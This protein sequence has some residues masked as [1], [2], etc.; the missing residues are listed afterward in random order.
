MS[1]H[2]FPKMPLL[3]TKLPNVIDAK[4]WICPASHLTGSTGCLHSRHILVFFLASK[5]DPPFD[6]VHQR[7][8]GGITI[9]SCHSPPS[10]I[11]PPAGGPHAYRRWFAWCTSVGPNLPQQDHTRIGCCLVV[12]ALSCPN[13]HHHPFRVSCPPLSLVTPLIVHV[14]VIVLI[15]FLKLFICLFS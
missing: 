1:H 6:V 9:V 10:R 13:R 14:F 2:A 3:F 12:Y 4:L 5:P 11:S 8:T 15:Y 7:S